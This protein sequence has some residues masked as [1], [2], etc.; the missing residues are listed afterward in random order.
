[1]RSSGVDSG[2]RFTR[3]ST[4]CAPCS[5]CDALS[6]CVCASWIA[7]C[8]ARVLSFSTVMSGGGTVYCAAMLWTSAVADAISG[9][10]G[11]DGSVDGVAVTG[12]GGVA[13]G[14]AG[15]ADESSFFGGGGGGGGGATTGFSVSDRKRCQLTP[16]PNPSINS[17]L[18]SLKARRHARRDAIRRV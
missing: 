7:V 2:S 12:I 11:F 4:F 14:F 13:T 8:T 10:V 3:R 1:M 5:D 15:P 16:S 18:V 9:L 6:Y 17:M